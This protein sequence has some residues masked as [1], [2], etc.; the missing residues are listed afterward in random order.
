MVG[1]KNRQMHSFNSLDPSTAPPP[2]KHLLWHLLLWHQFEA[3]APD[4]WHQHWICAPPWNS[5]R[6]QFNRIVPLMINSFLSNFLICIVPITCLGFFFFLNRHF[7]QGKTWKDGVMEPFEVKSE[8][9]FSLGGNP[10]F[11]RDKNPSK[12]FSKSHS[13]KS[14]KFNSKDIASLNI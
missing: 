12:V 7:H 2:P 3:A 11:H 14:K 1:N 5:V 8:T 6:Y 4:L 9:K 10:I 13:K